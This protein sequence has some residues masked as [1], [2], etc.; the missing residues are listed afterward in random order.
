MPDALRARLAAGYGPVQHLRSPLV[1]ALW[2]APFA[3][4]ALVAAPLAFEMRRDAGLLGWVGTWGASLAQWLIGL[5]LLVAALRESVPGRAWSRPWAAL[6]LTVPIAIVALVT[7][8]SWQ[9]SPVMLGNQWG[10]VAAICFTG[11]AASALPVVALA[12][13]LAAGAYPTR[14]ALAGAL[15]GLGAGLMADAGWRLFCHF[16][17]P[18]HV[19]S[20]HLGAV[21]L[22]MLAGSWLAR[23]ICRVQRRS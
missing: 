17:D 18:A 1:R 23:V 15:L 3:V 5:A 21:L 11:S 16:S 8:A 4:L 9:T 22:S 7:V 6:W 14:P 19:F 2:L 10:L 20:A 12:G 13:I